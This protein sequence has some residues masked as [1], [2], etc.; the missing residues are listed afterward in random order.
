MI[1]EETLMHMEAKPR[2]FKEVRPRPSVDLMLR[3]AQQQHMQ[4]SQM[5][6]TKASILITVS[7][8]ALTIA[9]SRSGDPELR[10]AL[11]TLAF[12]CLVSLI[13]AVI[14]VL[15]MFGKEKGR[16]NLLFF[17][18][19]AEMTED[20]FM[21]AIEQIAATD[22]GVYAAITRDIH[23]LGT[24]LYRKKYRFLRY[25]YIALITG[26]IIATMVEVYVLTFV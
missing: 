26:F 18:H 20:E 23:S 2:H 16:R 9:L 22:E 1:G 8:I 19:F 7:S 13:L 15:P 10:A 14:A 12:S 24:Y 4:L 5:A 21:S 17:G 11:L 25:A 3:T 6:D